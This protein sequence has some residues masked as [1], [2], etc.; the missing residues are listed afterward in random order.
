MRNFQ[1][2]AIALMDAMYSVIYPILG[3]MGAFKKKLNYVDCTVQV[4]NDDASTL[5]VEWGKYNCPFRDLGLSAMS[6]IADQIQQYY[7][8]AREGGKNNW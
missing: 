1:Y 5:W 8:D 3:E 7:E 2:E 6:T 4:V